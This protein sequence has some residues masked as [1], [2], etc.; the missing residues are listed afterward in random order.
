ME[1]ALD[2]AFQC[3][4]D[5]PWVKQHPDWF[6]IR[7]DG[8]IQYA[9]NPP[10]RYQDIYPLNFESK[11]WRGL[12]D[13]LYGV[14]N[15]WVDHDV[16]VFR[17]DNPHTKALAFWE[18]CIAEI[19]KTHPEVIFLAEAF[20]RPHVMYSLAKGGYTQ[21]YTYFTWRTE[22]A[23]L[24]EYF[25]EI[26]NPPVSDFFRPNV[27]PNTP[28]ILHEQLQEKDPARRRAVFQLRAVLAATLSAN[29]GIYGPAFELCEGRAAKA[30][31]GKTGSEE[32]LDSEKYQL[33]QWDRKDPI[34]IAPL[35]TRLNRIRRE[36]PALER[37]EHLVFHDAPNPQ[38]LC[39]SKS[40]ADGSNTILVVV[41]LD[42]EKE[43]TAWLDLKLDKL[44]L[45]WKG[46]FV[47]EDLLSRT[48]YDWKDQWNYVALRPREA[49]AH[50]FRI[51]RP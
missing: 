24:Q 20:T 11:E 10:K 34:S 35:I 39:Y 19:H 30:A 32:Y 43:Q 48:T 16:L 44:G 46:R 26:C 36:N 1:I 18:W 7:P 5:H 27:W 6:T 13:A 3:S 9:E 25:E 49:V 2:I 15:F 17:V 12:W 31:A 8:S 37:N 51:V 33:R 41:N 22:K 14:F 21:G 29:W 38:L 40:T 50:V 28:D 23:E 45:P 4:P 42:P 47:V